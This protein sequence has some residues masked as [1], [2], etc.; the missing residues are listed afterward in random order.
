MLDYGGT[1]QFQFAH[2]NPILYCRSGYSFAF[3][4]TEFVPWL[5][6]VLLDLLSNFFGEIET[7]F[8]VPDRPK[9]YSSIANKSGS[10]LALAVLV[11]LFRS[12]VSIILY[13]NLYY[14]H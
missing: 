4:N 12:R 5:R 1:Y 14:Y 3:P 8:K 10:E 13:F 6:F 11:I 2:L 7:V 9:M